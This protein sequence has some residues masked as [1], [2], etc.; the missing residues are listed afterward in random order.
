MSPENST[1]KVCPTC[2]TRLSENATRCLVCGRNFSVATPVKNEKSNPVEGPRLPEL[3]LSLPAALGLIVLILALGAAIIFLVLQGTGHVTTPTETPTLTITPTN[4]IAQ[5]TKE[6]TVAA[7]FTPLPPIQ[8]VIKAGDLCSS[9]AAYYKVSINSLIETNN[10]DTNCTLYPGNTIMI[11]QPTP[12]A[13]AQPTGTLSPAEATS[14]ACQT[15]PY[16]VVA[17][18]TVSSISANYNISVESIKSFNN[19]PSDNVWVGENLSLPLCERLPTSGPTP[20]PTTPPPY[21]AP[22]LLLPN[23]GIV[24]SSTTDIISLQWSS[25]GTLREN[26][27]YMVTIEDVSAEGAKRNVQYVT[28]TKVNVP[29]NLRPTDNTSHIFR[30]WVIAARQTGSNADGTPIYVTNGATS[31]MR[32][33]GWAGTSG[34]SVSPTA[35]ATP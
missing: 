22:N 9:L 32:V 33:F 21:S 1:T 28:D 30:W 3:K 8:Y 29:V 34:G 6:P 4:T 35:T 14:A 15:I 31:S 19:L 7:T 27:V 23:D 10:L 2:G 11:P 24:Y 25:V 26:E 20:T 5:P 17:N 16:V 12:T 18:D 13:T